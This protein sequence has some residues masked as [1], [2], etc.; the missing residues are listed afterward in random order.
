MSPQWS[1]VLSSAVAGL[2]LLGLALVLWKRRSRAVPAPRRP[3]PTAAASTES[4]GMT[5]PTCRR[6]YG[7]GTRFCAHDARPLVARVHL[8]AAGI[9]H[10][11]RLCARA[12]DGSIRFCPFDGAELVGAAGPVLVP[13]NA[14]SAEALPAG[15]LRICPQCAHR[16]R[17]S[18][19]FCLADG[20]SLVPLN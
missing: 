14:G 15:A 1:I 17:G 6:E 13:P 19:S 20:A 18:E 7:P 3:A 12:F 5:C 8:E 2:G 9:G 4:D 16:Y 10:T 11:C